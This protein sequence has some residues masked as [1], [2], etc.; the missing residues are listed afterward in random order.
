MYIFLRA[1]GND[2]KV[3]HGSMKGDEG[4]KA[5]TI[6]GL[7]K[8]PYFFMHGFVR[9]ESAPYSKNFRVMLIFMDGFLNL[10]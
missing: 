5:I 1:A 7:G 2:R 9:Y 3:I 4:N 6:S 8:F 10:L